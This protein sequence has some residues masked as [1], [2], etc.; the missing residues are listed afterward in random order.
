MFLGNGFHTP[1][2][3]AALF[4]VV[5]LH[6][7]FHKYPVP[8]VDCFLHIKKKCC[9]FGCKRIEKAVQS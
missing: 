5:L 3:M 7:N 9:I 1:V 4:F 2:F 8:I 6:A